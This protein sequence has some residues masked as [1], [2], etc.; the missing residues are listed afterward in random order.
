MK[1]WF[2]CKVHL[3]VINMLRRLD[4]IIRYVNQ[5]AKIMEYESTRS[6]LGRISNMVIGISTCRGQKSKD[7]IVWKILKTLAPTYK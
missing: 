4:Y 7:E 2:L 3:K 6:S 1:F 5:D